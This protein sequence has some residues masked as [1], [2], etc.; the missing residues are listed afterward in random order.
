MNKTIVKAKLKEFGFTGRIVFRKH[1]EFGQPD[2]CGPAIHRRLLS[3]ESDCSEVVNCADRDGFD[4]VVLY[5]E[6]KS[7]Y[8]ALENLT[9]AK[10]V[11]TEGEINGLR[12]NL[13]Y[14]TNWSKVAAEDVR[15]EIL[16]NGMPE[17]R[18][19]KEQTKFGLSWLKRTQWKLNGELR[20]GAF[21]GVREA[22]IIKNFARFEFVGLEFVSVNPYTGFP[23]CIAP[24][25]K[26][27]AKNGE[28]FT[29][30]VSPMG[31]FGACYEV[32]S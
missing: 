18:I 2:D 11:W 30:R 31:G 13:G 14:C 19:T 8:L 29:Y 7:Y 20:A 5:M 28:S 3:L 22:R 23:Q 12:R 21:I 1:N 24:L 32:V 15:E 26:T 17:F 27:I 9:D 4:T 10:H 16:R 25:Y 6:P